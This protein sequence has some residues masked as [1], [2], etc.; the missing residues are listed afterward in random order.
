MAGLAF[1]SMS[2]NVR[3][4]V[5]NISRMATGHTSTGLGSYECS[6]S[7]SVEIMSFDPVVMYIN[8]FMSDFEINHLIDN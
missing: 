8:G 5:E 3:Q 6:N 4:Y 2:S 1:A 7:Y